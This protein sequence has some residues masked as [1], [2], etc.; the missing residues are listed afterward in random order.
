MSLA[1]YI[2]GEAEL[3]RRQE[4]L[5]ALSQFPIKTV[6]RNPYRLSRKE[7]WT[8]RIQQN[9]E[10][11]ELKMR[12]GWTA[13]HYLDALRIVCPDVASL[14]AN[15]RIFLKNLHAQMSDEQRAYW[16]PRAE[17]SEITGCYAQTELGHG[18]NLKGIETT[19]T[20]DPTTDDIV[21]NSPTLSSHKYWI[22]GLGVVATHALVIA[23]LIVAG[24]EL[25]N[26]V[27]L[28]QIRD[29][30]THDLLP[31]VQ[32]YEQG[33]KSLGTF[34]TM[35]NGVMKFSHKRIPRA[36]MLA[37]YASLDRDGTY[38]KSENKKHAYTSMVIIRSLMSQEIGLDVA[39]AIVIALEY[40]TFRRQFNGKDGKETRV[41][42]YA[43]VQNRL[44]PALCR[45]IAMVLVGREI[46]EQVENLRVDRLENLHL[47]TVGLKIWATE[48]GVRDVEVARLSCGGHGNMAAAGLG[49]IYAQLSPARTYEGDNYVLS[50]QIGNAVIKHWKRNA[51]MTV[52]AL[53]YLTLLRDSQ[54]MSQRLGV[55]TADSFLAPETQ[56]QIL[57]YRAAILAR[58]HILDTEQ[59]KDTSYDV[60]QLAM[61]HADLTYW[62]SLQN[63][64]CEAPREHETAIKTLVDVFALTSILESLGA[65]AGTNYLA[66]E[67]ISSLRDTHR[68][69]IASF[70]NH[71]QS[72][73]DA[74]GFTEIELNS[75]FA[76]ESQTPYEALVETARQSEM[77]DNR[78][79]RPTILQAR[80]LWKKYQGSASKL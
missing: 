72:I 28:V 26:H 54:R 48:H 53:S 33:E 36:Q 30:E 4:I 42:E 8:V 10:L 56:E 3:D 73:V 21:L 18:S 1:S 22:G 19:A 65:F 32:V 59:G 41:I 52:P 38:H 16:I 57:E 5:K 14:S 45:A 64:L 13:Q 20:F 46:K 35:D 9:I 80:K 25:G 60:F 63:K 68:S 62:R 70:S 43:S 79:V 2:W 51:Q 17:N 11:L 40:T 23:R 39:K 49:S 55:G 71:V 74:L 47:Q 7:L 61:S 29:L 37:R 31:N 34:A 76:R 6:C 69:C 15:Y 50:Q 66:Q 78:F 24:K 58:R 67:D 12:L 75:A 27:F 77:T 44:Y